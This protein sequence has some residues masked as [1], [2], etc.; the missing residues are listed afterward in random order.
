MRPLARTLVLTPNFTIAAVSDSYLRAT[1]TRRGSEEIVGRG[2][3][4]IFSGQPH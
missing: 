2:V 4:D 3:F 1:M